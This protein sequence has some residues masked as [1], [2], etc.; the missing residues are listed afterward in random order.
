MENR[1]HMLGQIIF[2][3]DAVK[4]MRENKIVTQ[5]KVYWLLPSQ[6]KKFLYGPISDMNFTSPSTQKKG[7]DEEIAGDERKEKK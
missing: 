2:A 4:R 5:E 3:V 1:A 7:M 6:G